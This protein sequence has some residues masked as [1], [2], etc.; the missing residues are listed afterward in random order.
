VNIGGA[1]NNNIGAV[2]PITANTG[3]NMFHAS[4]IANNNQLSQNNIQN[5]LKMQHQQQQLQRVAQNQSF[6]FSQAAKNT[7]K[8]PRQQV[9]QMLPNNTNQQSQYNTANGSLKASQLMYPQQLPQGTIINQQQRSQNN[10]NNTRPAKMPISSQAN[11][12]LQVVPTQFSA[13][14]NQVNGMMLNVTGSQPILHNQMYQ[15]N[16]PNANVN[17]QF[18]TLN[19]LPYSTN[20][21]QN[22]LKRI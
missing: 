21:N 5:H 16:T 15:N 6:N 9:P 1:T 13:P 3:Q 19:P 18:R 11:P 2:Q 14:T 12:S 22:T 17:N 8:N 4:N 10:V 20:I 7:V